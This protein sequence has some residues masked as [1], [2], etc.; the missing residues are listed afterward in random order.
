MTNI[1]ALLETT[2]EAGMCRRFGFR[3]EMKCW[4]RAGS[5]PAVRG[6]YYLF[7]VNRILYSITLH[8]RMRPVPVVPVPIAVETTA[9][10]DARAGITRPEIV[11]GPLNPVTGREIFTSDW[12]ACE[13]RISISA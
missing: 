6:A 11:S 12:I 1:R 13:Q 3:T 9:A 8:H 4:S 5:D 10:A 2:E 7:D